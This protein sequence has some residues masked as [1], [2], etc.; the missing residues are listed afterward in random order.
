M[1][2]HR[3]KHEPGL[4]PEE[5]LSEL[6]DAA[7]KDETG[8]PTYSSVLGEILLYG[9]HF[10]FFY[11]WL[12]PKI[13][14][15]VAA[16]CEGYWVCARF[17]KPTGLGYKTDTADTQWRE[18]R[19]SLPIL[20]ITM[21]GITVAHYLFLGF[22]SLKSSKSGSGATASAWFRLIVGLVFLSVQHGR[23]ALVVLLISYL[24]YRVAKWQR[25]YGAKTG[26]ATWCFALFVLLFKES[27]RLLHLPQLRF[28]RPVFDHDRYGGMYSWRLPANFLV[29]RIISFSMDYHWA[30]KYWDDVE[31]MQ[32]KRSQSSPGMGSLP[33]SISRGGSSASLNASPSLSSL[34]STD[35][36]CDAAAA[37]AGAVA[38]GGDASSSTKERNGGSGVKATKAED[39]QASL[40]IASAAETHRPLSQYN[41]VNYLSYTLYA[42]LYIAGP[43]I[44]FNAFV[45]N[46]HN[47]QR[48]EDPLLYGIRWLI[49]L[50]LM[51]FL[52][53]RF[54]FFAVVQ[55]GLFPYLS[56]AEL[57][58]TAYM[59]L[60]MMWLKFLIVWRFFRLW[61]LADGTLPPE[62]MLRCMSN[63]CSLETFWR[64]WHSSFNKWIVRY[65]YKPLGGRDSRMWS[66]WPIFLFVAIWHDIEMKL[67]VWGLLNALFYVIEVLAKR[68]ASKMRALPSSVFR[69]IC[70]LSGA[71]YI[72]V[73]I[74]VNLIG[75]SVGVGGVGSILLKLQSWEGFRMLVASYY[76]LSLTVG[77]MRLLQRLGFSKP[78]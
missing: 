23:H 66:V 64:A 68:L 33:R 35:K 50:A 56:P 14:G 13:G 61:A 72:L 42:P 58:I 15:Q 62:N 10:I 36:L 37:G 32:R 7:V 20:W 52:T 73:L 41:F 39:G 65:M 75:Y 77:L 67:L 78:L 11:F 30:G 71:T 63:N 28:L 46:T 18:L 25:E 51:E 5:N 48:A 74:G 4:N 70:I 44:S 3:K 12:V 24:G 40:Q 34:A 16:K 21:I 6:K 69:L 54:P 53:N 55:S 59:T 17:I 76:F 57:A 60:K 2:R 29:L 38:V 49:C 27:Y 43:I 47:R 45:E 22:W 9:I 1:S 31:Q 19:R 26:L 8:R